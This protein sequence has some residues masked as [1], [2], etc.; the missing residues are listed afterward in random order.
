MGRPDGA[1]ELPVPSAD[2]AFKVGRAAKADVKHCLGEHG[3]ALSIDPHHRFDDL[4]LV[5]ERDQRHEIAVA[6][7]VQ[8]PQAGL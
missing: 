4:D 6:E 1:I 3:P 2:A 7:E 5:V 8:Q